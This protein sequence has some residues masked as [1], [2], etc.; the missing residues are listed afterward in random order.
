M[1]VLLTQNSSMI[2]SIQWS[3]KLQD[4][5]NKFCREIEGDK[6]S[7]ERIRNMRHRKH[8]YESMQKPLGRLILFLDAVIMVAQWVAVNRPGGAEEVNALEFLLTIDE[9]ALICV[10]LCADAGD[11]GIQMVRDVDT[12]KHDTSR[13]ATILSIIFRNGFATLTSLL[14]AR[15]PCSVHR[16]SQVVLLPSQIS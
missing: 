9:E 15:R 8:R 13:V 7:G 12:E 11:E 5:F 10:A 3:H 4:M 16:S 1:T 14:P 6:V 2:N